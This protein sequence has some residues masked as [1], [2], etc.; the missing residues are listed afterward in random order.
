[1]TIDD[2]Y[3]LLRLWYLTWLVFKVLQVVSVDARRIASLLRGGGN[4]G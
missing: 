3:G 1:M 2:I 4:N